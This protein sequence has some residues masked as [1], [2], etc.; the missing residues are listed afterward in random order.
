MNIFEIFV[1]M[2]HN[3]STQIKGEY[4]VSGH[5]ESNGAEKA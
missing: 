4:D 1:V 5:A 3:I 2:N